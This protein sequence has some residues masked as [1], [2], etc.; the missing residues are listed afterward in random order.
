MRFVIP[1]Y[2]PQECYGFTEV[3]DISCSVI[4][5]FQ[6]LV[7]SPPLNEKCCKLEIVCNYKAFK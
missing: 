4:R 7:C 1:R 6:E 5:L 2:I 3:R